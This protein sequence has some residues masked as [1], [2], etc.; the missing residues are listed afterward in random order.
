M[1]NVLIVDTDE[2]FINRM[3]EF[4]FKEAGIKNVLTAS[5]VQES[6][7]Q[8]SKHKPDMILLDLLPEDINCFDAVEIIN[9]LTN[10]TR[11]LI[12]SEIYNQEYCDAAFAAG[13]DAFV[14]KHDFK[15]DILTIIN[16]VPK[17]IQFLFEK[18]LISKN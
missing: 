9:R 12:T 14:D 10:S 1:K 15:D 6:L 4:L 17:N 18:Y 11:I 5:T 13:A 3:N 2:Q 16:A 8:I 7:E